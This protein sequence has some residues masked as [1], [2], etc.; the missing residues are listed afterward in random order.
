MAARAVW[1]VRAGRWDRHAVFFYLV[2]K[3]SPED[4]GMRKM[5]GRTTLRTRDQGVELDGLKGCRVCLSGE[6]AQVLFKLEYRG[7]IELQR[8]TTLFKKPLLPFIY[9]SLSLSVC[10]RTCICV[11]I[12]IHIHSRSQSSACR[13][14]SLLY[15]VGPGDDSESHY[16]LSHLTR[17]YCTPS[18]KRRAFFDE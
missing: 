12:C 6:K 10:V 14:G 11:C 15:H 8:F 16:S 13:S 9:L 18:G 5:S 7:N 3:W 17:P 2:G 1:A 4:R